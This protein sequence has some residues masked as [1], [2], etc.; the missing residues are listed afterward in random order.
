MPHREPQE[1]HHIPTAT[2]HSARRRFLL[3]LQDETFAG[4]LLLGAALLALLWANSPWRESYQALAG[5]E[6]GPA[7]LHLDL[8]L[9]TWAADGLLAI[10]FFVVG[11]ELKTEF[12]TGSL[13]KLDEALLPML[14][15][16]LGMAV[17]ALIYVAVQTAT[18]SGAVDGWA[19]PTAT[20]IAFAVA[21]LGIFGRGLPP[22]LR[23]F[24]LTL[25]VVDDLLA[26]TV[27]AVFY[28]E[29]ISLLHLLASLALIALFGF[30][31]QRRVLHWW[32]LVP[33]AVVAWVFMHES[34][35]HATV[36]GVL[37][38]M[39]VPARLRRG[40]P[41][42]LTHVFV[43][44]VQPI[45][46]G[47]ALPVFAFFAAGVSVIDSG[48]VSEIL[49]DPITI[50]VVAGLVLGKVLGIW[51]GVALLVRTTRLRLGHGVDLSDL[52]GVAML[53]GIGFTVSLLIAELSF[54]ATA[55]GDHAKFA[56]IVGS[57]ISA[58]LGGITLRARARVRVRGRGARVAHLEG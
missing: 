1:H 46:A 54:G 6:V 34:G 51:G 29:E 19:I 31:V 7:A 5:L 55:E 44:R 38:G 52:L 18:G 9:S 12:V 21:L 57:V 25:A 27:I 32:L 48:G 4:S 42:Q 36:A 30:L 2:A 50:G 33:L 26:I 14:A 37:L 13:R 20:D 47:F 35:V 58:A 8:S 15:A 16:V 3:R 43:E 22:A 56:V 17:P 11:L 45:S 28:T 53:A 23:V 49:G 40:D 24:L 39:T 10:F 41:A